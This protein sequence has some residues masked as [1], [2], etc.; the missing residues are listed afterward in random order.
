M[1]VLILGGTG[2]VGQLT[3]NQLLHG[4]HRVT[5]LVRNTQ[6]LAAHPGLKQCPTTALDGSPER[7]QSILREVDTV[8][9]CLGHRLSVN[10]LFGHP[11]RLV[12]DSLQR[13]I[14]LMSESDRRRIRLILLGSSGCQNTLLDEPRSR[15]ERLVF[16]T[17]RRVLPPHVDNEQAAELLVQAR[18]SHTELN[19]VIVRPD[20]LVDEPTVSPYRVVESP[21]RSPLF[22][23][24][25]V[26]RI[27]VAHFI[28]A[29]VTDTP[30][31]QQWQHRMPVLYGGRA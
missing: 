10:G 8:I 27:N 15:A 11:R 17:L 30:L 18:Y 1:H 12:R 19:W 13:L 2:A 9:S 20:S 24:G 31:W 16:A 25:K 3:V 29:L 28:A 26:S 6:V 7:L 22:D 5:A 21:E 23:A 4:G 14:A